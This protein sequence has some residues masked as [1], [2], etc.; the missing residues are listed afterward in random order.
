MDHYNKQNIILIQTIHTIYVLN[1]RTVVFMQQKICEPLEAF[2]HPVFD[3]H[4]SSFSK[5]GQ[6][7]IL[8]FSFAY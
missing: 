4:I 5:C 2:S 6:I 7:R 8:N 1:N 3:D